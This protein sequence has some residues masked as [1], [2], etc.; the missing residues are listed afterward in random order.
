MRAHRLC[1]QG[2]SILSLL[3]KRVKVAKIPPFPAQHMCLVQKNYVFQV[4]VPYKALDVC[5]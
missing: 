1:E 4:M 2:S 5:F 3:E